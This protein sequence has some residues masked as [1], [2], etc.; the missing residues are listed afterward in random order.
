MTDA[1]TWVEEAGDRVLQECERINNRL[2]TLQELS[3][4]RLCILYYVTSYI[5][6]IKDGEILNDEHFEAL[7]KE[8]MERDLS[9]PFL[10]E[11][12]TWEDLQAGTGYALQYRPA[13]KR[14]SEYCYLRTG[15]G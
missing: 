5:Y 10:Y 9:D 1:S 8:L 13:I 11:I 4:R 2:L 14:I 15:G 12:P 3:T 6:Y 7:C